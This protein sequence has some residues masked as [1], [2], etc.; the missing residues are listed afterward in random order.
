MPMFNQKE[1]WEI[2]NFQ[3]N[4]KKVK[5][6]RSVVTTGTKSLELLT[7]VNSKKKGFE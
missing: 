3:S 4:F 6:D 7:I 1:G 2:N 5:K